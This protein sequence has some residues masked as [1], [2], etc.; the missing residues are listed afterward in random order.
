MFMKKSAWSCVDNLQVTNVTSNGNL[1]VSSGCVMARCS[2]LLGVGCRVRLRVV[3][4][5]TSIRGVALGRASVRR[6]GRRP[7][8]RVC[9]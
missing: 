7:M 1:W 5:S 4:C 3:G 8:C 6:G 9:R 2:R